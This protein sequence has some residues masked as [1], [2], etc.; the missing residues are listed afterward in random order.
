MQA[1]QLESSLAEALRRA[2]KNGDVAD[3]ARLLG[4]GADAVRCVDTYGTTALHAVLQPPCSLPLLQLLLSSVPPG[5]AHSI[6]STHPDAESVAEYAVRLRE[7]GALGSDALAAIE[8]TRLVD[9]GEAAA[10]LLLPPST[11]VPAALTVAGGATSAAADAS[12]DAEASEAEAVAALHRAVKISDDEA[13]RA[14]LTAHFS[15]RSLF[16]IDRPMDA[17]GTTALIA[18]V[19]AIDRNTNLNAA[20]AVA[21]LTL[22]LDHGATPSAVRSSDPD[23]ESALEYASRLNQRTPSARMQGVLALLEGC[24]SSIMSSGDTGTGESPLHHRDTVADTTVFVVG[25]TNESKVECVRRA[26]IAIDGRRRTTI[27][28]GGDTPSGVSDQPVGIEETVKG[29][30]NRAT[31]VL[32]QREAASLGVGL[33]SGIV[34]IGASVFDFCACAIAIVQPDGTSR[35]VIGLSSFW[36]LPPRVGN[37]LLDGSGGYNEVRSSVCVCARV[38]VSLSL[39][40]SLSPSRTHRLTISFSRRTHRPLQLVAFP[41]IQLEQVFLARSAEWQSL[42]EGRWRRVCGTLFCRY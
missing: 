30:R 1:S 13:V 24:T 39:S 32:Q 35:T 12:A 20:R 42:V 17:Y 33:E 21:V 3:A 16:D 40:L 10:G 27:V 41:P 29:A 31:F 5:T 9:A 37:A 36:M 7:M 6:I 28:S 2:A 23:A 8:A 18:A 11:P 4:E 14:S 22:L 38:C 19:T 26:F 25:T 15:Q 34:L